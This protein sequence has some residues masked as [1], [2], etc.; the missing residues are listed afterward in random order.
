MGGTFRVEWK[1]RVDLPFEATHQMYNP[2]NEGK[3]VRICRDGQEVP[4][5]LGMQLTRMMDQLAQDA[6]IPPPR[7]AAGAMQPAGKA[8]LLC[9]PETAL[10]LSW[11][12]VPHEL[13]M[14]L[15]C[16][17]DQLAQE[18]GIP[19]PRP[20]AGAMRLAGGARVVRLRKGASQSVLA[21]EVSCLHSLACQTSQ[22][23]DSKTYGACLPQFK[24]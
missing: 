4:H 16:M 22:L 14:Q 3:P 7:P 20:A 1:R 5:E 12:E 24:P 9:M 13:G 10:Q 23:C 19:L 18:A 21:G 6:G 8:P 15:T 11:Q 17:M 2:L